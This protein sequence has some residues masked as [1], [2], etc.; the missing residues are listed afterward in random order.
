VR[1]AGECV[2]TARCGV[3]CVL[4]DRCS[5]ELRVE[6][7]HVLSWYGGLVVVTGEEYYAAELKPA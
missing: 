5:Y 4:R 2:L 7:A 3:C 1:W 6:A